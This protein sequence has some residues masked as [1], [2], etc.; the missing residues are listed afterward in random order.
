MILNDLIGFPQV[1]SELALRNFNLRRHGAVNSTNSCPTANTFSYSRRVS[2]HNST[3]RMVLQT[4]MSIPQSTAEEKTN[5]KH[6][7]KARSLL[8]MALPNEHQ[9]TYQPVP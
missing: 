4:K 8:L 1:G 5:K 2:D 3:M 9:L 7:V 6:D